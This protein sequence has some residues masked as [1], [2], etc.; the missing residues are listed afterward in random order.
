MKSYT[1][2]FK[3]FTTAQKFLTGAGMDATIALDRTT[4]TFYRL[5]K[6][7]PNQAIEEASAT[8]LNGPWSVVKQSI[9]Y[10]TLPAGE[11]PLVFQNNQSPSKV[12]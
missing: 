4:N 10:P 12:R 7:G 9:G 3:T 8:S 1:T 5:S 6:N 2:D 11:G